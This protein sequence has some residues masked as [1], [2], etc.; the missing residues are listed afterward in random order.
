MSAV[1]ST[2]CLARALTDSRLLPFSFYRKFCPSP[3]RPSAASR[4]CG[5]ADP[6]ARVAR[7][8]SSAYW[9]ASSVLRWLRVDSVGMG[10]LAALRGCCLGAWAG[11][12]GLPRRVPPVAVAGRWPSGCVVR[13]A[14]SRGDGRALREMGSRGAA[15]RAAREGSRRPRVMGG[16][17]QARGRPLEWQPERR[18]SVFAGAVR[19]AT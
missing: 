17:N 4:S 13:A 12:K 3:S 15:A 10:H 18:R 19:E 7:S 1:R 14:A 2:F 8:R 16:Q 11:L 5:P 9:M 6:A